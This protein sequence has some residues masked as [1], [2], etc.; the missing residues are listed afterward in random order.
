MLGD[1]MRRIV[2]RS[3]AIVVALSAHLAVLVALGYTSTSEII[4][5]ELPA[6][7][8]VEIVSAPSGH[9]VI[10]PPSPSTMDSQ[11]PV[12]V[13]GTLQASVSVEQ[14]NEPNAAPAAV[15]TAMPAF[16]QMPV[17]NRSPSATRATDRQ[18]SST[19][20]RSSTLAVT[21]TPAPLTASDPR[22]AGSTDAISASTSPS[23]VPS[24]WKVRLLSHLERHKRYPDAARVKRAEGTALLS[25]G[26]DRDGR[27]LG[28]ALVRSS[29]FP[30]LD[31]E[32]LAMIGRASP[33]PPAPPEIREQIVQLVVP[34]RFRM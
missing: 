1:W 4:I 17:V 33:L 2:T 8:E 18:T 28:Y 6:A 25:F 3:G 32:V 20:R 30:E 12:A 22:D 10:A 31:D 19:K 23:D 34:V 9:A 29:G 16:A 15:A 13:S 5:G 11:D 14:S 24:T 26:M 27:V 21:P 7:I